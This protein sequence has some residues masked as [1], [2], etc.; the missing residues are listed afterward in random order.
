MATNW[1]AQDKASSTDNFTVE[2]KPKASTTDN[3][4]V[5]T[6]TKASSTDNFTVEAKTKASSVVSFVDNVSIVCDGTDDWVQTELNIA[7]GDDVSMSFWAKDTGNGL[8]QYGVVG[9]GTYSTYGFNGRYSPGA[10]NAHSVWTITGGNQYGDTDSWPTGVWKH[11]IVTITDGATIAY[12]DSVSKLTVGGEHT[13]GT[14]RIGARGNA[15]GSAAWNGNINDVAIWDMV[16]P[17]A[18]ITA[19]Y[20]LGTPNNLTNS[21][22]Y[23]VDR[24][25][26]L[27][28][29]WKFEDDYL[30]S[31]GEENHG[32][33]AGN[34]AFNDDVPPDD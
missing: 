14:I 13:G 2:T 17:Q 10:A 20:N 3:F 29:Y 4:T 19:I 15:G 5:E 34:V 1:T 16:L 28:G 22:S 27:L 25:G 12:V 6:K 7:D 24:T 8:N 18:D 21:D 26:N 23:A 11:V 31:S 30:D 32:T 33:K 9:I